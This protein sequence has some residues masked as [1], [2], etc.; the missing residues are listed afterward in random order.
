MNKVLMVLVVLGML[1][2]SNPECP[3]VSGNKEVSVSMEISGTVES[4]R[5]RYQI[6][7]KDFV[8][9]IYINNAMPEVRELSVTPGTYVNIELE[10]LS[11]SGWL[12]L[13]LHANGQE[14]TTYTEE[15]YGSLSLNVLIEQ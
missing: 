14:Y 8:P 3:V 5:V 1:A 9:W 4:C 7:G 15:S 2:C 11:S 10:L 13:S 6:N 12:R